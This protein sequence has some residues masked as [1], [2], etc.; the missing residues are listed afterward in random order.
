MRNPLRIDSRLDRAA[1]Y[2]TAGFAIVRGTFV[3][4]DAGRSLYGSLSQWRAQ[5]EH[6]AHK[7]HWRPVIAVDLPWPEL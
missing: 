6:R 1:V 2:I 5:R 3:L 7:A 4:I